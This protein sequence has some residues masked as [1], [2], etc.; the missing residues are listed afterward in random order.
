MCDG[1]ATTGCEPQQLEDVGI[2]NKGLGQLYGCERP[3]GGEKGETDTRGCRQGRREKEAVQG[4]WWWASWLMGRQGSWYPQRPRNGCWA[5]T[6][7]VP[8]NSHRCVA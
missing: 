1:Y 3:R 2:M 5:E 6:Q 8:L 4:G 7:A